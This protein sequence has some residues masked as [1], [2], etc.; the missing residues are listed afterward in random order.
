MGVS[1]Q[2]IAKTL[3]CYL[4]LVDACCASLSDWV[5]FQYTWWGPVNGDFYLKLPR[6][7]FIVKSGNL[8]VADQRIVTAINSTKLK[9]ILMCDEPN[10]RFEKNRTL[11]IIVCVL[12]ND[13]PYTQISHSASPNP[14]LSNKGPARPWRMSRINYED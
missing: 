2:N 13:I 7:L 8:I 14:V 10:V 12:W 5:F 3:I 9:D 11:F 6:T 1:T 4:R